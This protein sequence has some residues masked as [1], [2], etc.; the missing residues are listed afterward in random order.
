MKAA[1][2]ISRNLRFIV[3]AFLAAA[4]AFQAVE[5]ST[6]DQKIFKVVTASSPGTAFV[7]GPSDRGQ[8]ILITAYHVIKGN[9]NSE[10]LEIL[11]P[12][13]QMFSINKAAF[14]YNEKLDLAFAAASSC[15][16]SLGLPLARATSI[17][18]STRVHIKGYPIDEE[19][20]HSSRV[21]PFTV[22]GRITQYNDS[23]TYDLNY[24]APTKPGYSGGPVINN[25]GLEL[26]AVHGL[27]D[28]VGD[29]WDHDL[30]EQLRVGGRGVSA[31]LL[32]KFLKEYGIILP[33]SEKSVCLVGV[34]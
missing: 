15:A 23:E 26:M 9:S 21:A 12:K 34:C 5:A 32:Y 19:V 8:C 29:S 28:T 31:P 18:V 24:D 11:T 2:K 13:G 1:T 27:S 7:I 33:R 4:S 30:R 6:V 10:P 17:T 22:T 16:N 3:T 25:D 14:K 20:S